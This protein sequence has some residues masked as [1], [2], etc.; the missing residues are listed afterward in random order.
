MKTGKGNGQIASIQVLSPLSLRT[1]KGLH[2][3]VSAVQLHSPE[4]GAEI[5]L[6][7]LIEIILLSA[8]CIFILKPINV[9]G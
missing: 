5:Q 6:S 7:S 2:L 1:V 4:K 3:S 9:M 8:A